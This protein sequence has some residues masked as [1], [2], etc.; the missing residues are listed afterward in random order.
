MR[1]EKAYTIFGLT[2]YS[3][4]DERKIKKIYRKLMIEHHPDHG[5]DVEKSKDINEAKTVL[6]GVAKALSSGVPVG[7]AVSNSSMQI[8]PF[9]SLSKIYGGEE[10]EGHER[11]TKDNIK[12]KNVFLN[13]EVS[14]VVNGHEF[15]FSGLDHVKSGDNYR[16][17]CEVKANRIDTPLSLKV[18]AYGKEVNLEISGGNASVNLTYDHNVRLSVVIERRIVA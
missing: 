9:D 17:F 1:V 16:I 11:L 15:E 6:D 10:W 18:V 4:I 5:G 12:N 3:H 14:V 2:P 7:G 8:I 13:I